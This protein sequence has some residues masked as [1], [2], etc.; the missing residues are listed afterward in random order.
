MIKLITIISCIVLWVLGGQ[1]KGRIRDVP[2]PLILALYFAVTLKTWWLFF[3][4]GVTYQIIRLGYG[5]YDP[6]FDDKP[7]HLAS[8]THDRDG[9]WIRAIW[10]LLVSGI[11]AFPLVFWGHIVLWKYIL[12][13]TV[14]VL[15][16]FSVSRFRLGVFLTDILV[17]L[18]L[19]S[20]VLL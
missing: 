4:L 3:V 15:A 7:S 12:Y 13:V 19:V 6:V 11:G 8:V 2:V 18:A 5:N 14:N 1:I 20:I 9:W 17:S 16:N 10:G